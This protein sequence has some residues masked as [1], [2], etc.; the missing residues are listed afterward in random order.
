MLPWPM[1]MASRL[2]FY[3]G[4]FLNFF[5]RVGF[6]AQ[7]FGDRRLV[8]DNNNT[9]INQWTKGLGRKWPGGIVWAAVRTSPSYPKKRVALGWL[10]WFL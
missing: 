8:P 2:R 3:K 6:K 4:I 1:T 5:G 9:T 7:R 10:R